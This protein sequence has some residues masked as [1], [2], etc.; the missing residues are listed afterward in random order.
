MININVKKLYIPGGII[1]PWETEP[2]PELKLKDEDGPLTKEQDYVFLSNLDDIEDDNDNDNL[3]YELSIEEPLPNSEIH[4]FG[5]MGQVVIIEKDGNG[6]IMIPLSM[7]VCI[8][9][10]G[11]VFLSPKQPSSPRRDGH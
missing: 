4:L 6:A 11:S 8:G 3:F 1:I 7:V 5:E 2:L 10:K 9:T